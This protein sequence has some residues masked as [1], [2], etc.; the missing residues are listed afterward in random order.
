M[1]PGVPSLVRQL[2]EDGLE[3][4]L[5]AGRNAPWTTVELTHGYPES[6]LN[7]AFTRLARELPDVKLGSYPG[8]PMIVRLQGDAEEVEAARVIVSDAIAALDA[9]EAGQRVRTAWSSRD[10][11]DEEDE[12]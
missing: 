10:E 1:L 12:T 3:P 4:Q 6:L 8:S 9:S 7:P 2:V 11:D 5:L